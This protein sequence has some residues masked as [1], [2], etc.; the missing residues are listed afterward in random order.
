[1]KLV[2]IVPFTLYGVFVLAVLLID[3]FFLDYE[4]EDTFGSFMVFIFSPVFGFMF[5]LPSELLFSL[6]HG[7]AVPGHAFI[8]FVTGMAFLASIDAWRYRRGRK[9]P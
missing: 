6:N 5:H 2:R 4:Y 9:H 1:M 7:R 3:R 8:S